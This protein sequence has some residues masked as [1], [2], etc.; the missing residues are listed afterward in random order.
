MFIDVG[1]NSG[2][3]FD[4][5][6]H[7]CGSSRRLTR[8]YMKV[9]NLSTL[10]VHSQT[11]PRQ[12][13]IGGTSTTERIIRMTAIATNTLGKVMRLTRPGSSSLTTRMVILSIALT[14]T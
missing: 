2:L 4:G 9:S 6:H 5:T 13:N 10:Q 8:H 12:P 1:G 3:K 11:L 7:Q 14:R